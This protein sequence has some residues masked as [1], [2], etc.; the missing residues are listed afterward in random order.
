[1]ATSLE[2]KLSGAIEAARILHRASSACHSVT[3]KKLPCIVFEPN[4]T[5]IPLE[6]EGRIL[7]WF[8]DRPEDFCELLFLNVPAVEGF[9][10]PE[11]EG[12]WVSASLVA[13]VGHQRKH[14]LAAVLAFAFASA[15]DAKVY[16]ESRIWTG[17]RISTP[18]DF[19]A[20]LKL[21]DGI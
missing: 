8:E 21:R 18:A 4:L 14:L 6:Y 1:M 5:Q 11:E 2:I 10:D 13:S 16:D 20:N 7:A 3:G 19:L 17:S 12:W 15:A 9:E